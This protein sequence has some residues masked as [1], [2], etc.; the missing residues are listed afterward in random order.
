MT[1]GIF[2]WVAILVAALVGLVKSSEFMNRSAERIGLSLGA[3]PFV[4]GVVLLA[5]GTSMPE[6]LTSMIAMAEGQSEII[7]GN[8]VGSNITNIFLI[9][10]VVGLVNASTIV[11]N[12]RH[13]QTDLNFLVGSAFLFGFI[14]MDGTFTRGEGVISIAGFVAYIWYIATNDRSLVEIELESLSEDEIAAQER[15]EARSQHVVRA[16]WSD[17][18]LFV[19]SGGVL[20]FSAEYAVRSVVEMSEQI[21]IATEVIATSAV[22]LGTSLP[23]LVVSVDAV[24]KDQ[25]EMALGNILGSCV[26]NIFLVAGASSLF[27]ELAVTDYIRIEAFLFMLAATLFCFWITREKRL[28]RFDGFIF[29]LF[30]LVFI[31]RLLGFL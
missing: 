29:L 9:L 23:E 18:T 28:G 26:F 30:Y 22:A 3:S 25:P 17:Y 15:A 27:G 31:G 4:V 10:G 12:L 2:F 7:M 21:G 16:K 11:F 13:I 14:I 19:L 6:L 1:D 5:F 20:F 8:V 24:R